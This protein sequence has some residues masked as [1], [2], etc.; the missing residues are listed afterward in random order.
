[1]EKEAHFLEQMVPNKP[2]NKDDDKG[3]G[4]IK[5]KDICND[6]DKRGVDKKK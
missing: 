5:Y 2:Q 6:K 4:A 1:V 3:Y